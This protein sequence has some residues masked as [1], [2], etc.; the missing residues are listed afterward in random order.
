[1]PDLP[2]PATHLQDLLNDLRPFDEIR[3]HL[4]QQIAPTGRGFVDALNKWIKAQNAPTYAVKEQ[5]C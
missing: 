4:R 1:M 5:V 3:H 2:A